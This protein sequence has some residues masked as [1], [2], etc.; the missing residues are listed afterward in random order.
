M[1]KDAQ[2][3]I[4]IQES[5]GLLVANTLGF[6]CYYKKLLLSAV[7]IKPINQNLNLGLTKASPSYQCNLAFNF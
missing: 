3:Q 6:E 7:Y 4:N 1:A 2:N 5:G